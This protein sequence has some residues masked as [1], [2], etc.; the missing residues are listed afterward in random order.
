MSMVTED[1]MT[2]SR[3][4][5]ATV[6]TEQCK[7][8]AIREGDVIYRCGMRLLVDREIREHI[9]YDEDTVWSTSAVIENWDQVADSVGNLALVDGSGRRRWTIQGNDLAIWTREVR[10]EQVPTIEVGDYVVRNFDLTG[11]PYKVAAVY[12]NGNLRASYKPGYSYQ[13]P[14]AMFVKVPPCASG[15]HAAG[16][17]PISCKHCNPRDR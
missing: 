1:A 17:G 9:A 14:S 5:M 15:L 16:H 12:K 2:P 8:S 11:Q 3:D 6:T 7:T 10:T 13:G 4:G